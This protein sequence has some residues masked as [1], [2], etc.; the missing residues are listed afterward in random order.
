MTDAN[1][2]LAHYG[3]LGMKWGKH[4]SRVS[5]DKSKSAASETTRNIS[6]DHLAKEVIKKK[7]VS[8]MSNDELRFLTQR[9]QLEK[10]YSDLNNAKSV[11]N[12]KNLASKIIDGGDKVNKVVKLANSPAGKAAKAVAGHVL[13]NAGWILLGAMTTTA[14]AA[15]ATKYG[16]SAAPAFKAIGA[17]TTRLAIER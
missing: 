5:S 8:E 4:K 14:G 6:T 17:A 2:V 1:D 7:H 12:G 10:Q 13:S 9:M 16:P 3:V 11:K 15:A